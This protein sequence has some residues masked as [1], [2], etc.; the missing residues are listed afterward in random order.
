MDNKKRH[1]RNFKQS[2]QGLTDV[3]RAKRLALWD[4]ATANMSAYMVGF[5]HA[6]TGVYKP[7]PR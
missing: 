6:I 5:Y 3:E 2:L 1:R 4:S 7:K